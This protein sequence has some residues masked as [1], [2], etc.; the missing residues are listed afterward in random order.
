MKKSI[1]ILLCAALLLPF[2]TQAQKEDK[3][4]TQQL[5][6]FSKVIIEGH[7]DVHLYPSD[8]N[9][10]RIEVRSSEIW[11]RLEVEEKGDVLHVYYR[12]NSGKIGVRDEKFIVQLAYTQLDEL[13]VMGKIW[14]VSESVLQEDVLKITGEGM[15]KG[16]LDVEVNKLLVRMHG[17][18]RMNVSGEAEYAK[19][20]LEGMGKIDGAN[21]V[22]QHAK[23]EV[24][25]WA[26]TKIDVR[27]TYSASHGGIGSINYKGN[28]KKKRIS[29][30]GISFVRGN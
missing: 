4:K 7:A 6:E 3:I 24:E 29:R 11:D 13:E 26:K 10:L 8:R 2:F 23:T 19:F 16:E 30:E 25:G 27:E 20:E 15:I 28:P 9:E 18:I 21:L 1:F 12:E 5:S 17:L 14:L 22:A